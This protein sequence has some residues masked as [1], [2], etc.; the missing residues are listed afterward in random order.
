M[1]I[2]NAQNIADQVKEFQTAFQTAESEELW[3]KLIN[4]EADEVLKA[5]Q[6]L[7]KETCDLVY[8]MVGLA[9]LAP[10]NSDIAIPPELGHKLMFATEYVQMM[11]EMLPPG[12]FED[13]FTRVHLSNMSK[14]G[15]DGKPIRREDGK[16]LKG[17]NYAPPVLE[18][19]IY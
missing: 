13:A 6:E 8:V 7:L 4:E 5:A 14:L 18:D 19:L 12:G 17:P 16:V 11:A 10:K 9:N 3:I 1:T 2:G 15:E